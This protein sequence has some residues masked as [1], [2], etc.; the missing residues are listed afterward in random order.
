MYSPAQLLP[1][2]GDAIPGVTAYGAA[3]GLPPDMAA[4]M[5]TQET[6][7]QTAQNQFL[8]KVEELKTSQAAKRTAMKAGQALI[9]LVRAKAKPTLGSKYSQNWAALGFAGSSLQVPRTVD[10]LVSTLGTMAGHLTTYPQFGGQDFDAAQADAV[11]ESLQAAVATVNVKKSEARQKFEDRAAKAAAARL[12]LRTVLSA[13]KLKFDP[14]DGRW[15]EF[16]FKRPGVK[17]VPAVPKGVTAV[18]IG[19]T[20]I[21]VKWPPAAR[22]AHYRLWLKIIGQDSELV[23]IATTTDLDALLES[24]PSN[25]QVEIALS[26]ANSG[27]ESAKSQ[28]ILVLTE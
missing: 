6:D 9:E 15:L 26:A 16:G 13:L 20:A 22:A 25:S 23:W 27:G 12:S 4:T 8:D 3:V 17:S 5:T 1:Q 19:P 14:L 7:L 11:K 21:A 18:L 10:G 28:S 2:I 24:L